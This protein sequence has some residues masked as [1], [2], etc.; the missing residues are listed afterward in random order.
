MKKLKIITIMQS[1]LIV[2]L[3]MLVVMILLLK[4]QASEQMPTS[5]TIDSNQNPSEEEYIYETTGEKIYIHDQKTGRSWVP[6]FAD[7]PVCRYQNDQFITRNNLTYYTENQK[8][9]SKFGIDVSAHDGQIDWQTV[10]KAGVDFAFIRVGYRGY[11]S[12]AIVPDEYYLSNVQGA[13]EAG[14]DIGL[15]FYSQ[16][17]TPA[18]ALEE[19]ETV[20]TAIGDAEITYP[21]VFDWEFVTTDTAR[22][23]DISAKTLTE[24]SIAFCERIQQA[25]YLPMIYQNKSTS[26]LNLNLPELTEYDFWLAE[27][28]QE[29]SYYYDYQIWQYSDSGTIP[30]I[31]GKVDVNICFKD[32]SNPEKKESDENA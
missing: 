16:A 15:Y 20:L 2:L 6:V 28:N 14:I 4:K 3:I 27:Y 1:L 19:A 25:G 18:E 12:G 8:I 11:A 13:L 26:L 29:A 31:K 10:K 23:D 5:L 21:I 30:G 22:T 7:V 24:C 9:I 17:I 32:Y